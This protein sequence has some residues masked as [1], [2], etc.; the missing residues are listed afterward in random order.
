[1][2]NPTANS[3]MYLKGIGQ[4]RAD[5]LAKEGIWSAWDLLHYFPRAYIDRNALDSIKLLIIKLLA[6]K[7]SFLADPQDVKTKTEYVVTATVTNVEKRTYGKN[8]KYLK[9]GIQDDYDGKA[10]IIFWNFADY[11]EKQYSVGDKIFVCGNPEIDKY[12]RLQFSQ[13]EIHKYDFEEFREYNS[14][15]IPVYKSPDSF[16][17]VGISNSLLRRVIASLIKEHTVRIDETLPDNILHKFGFPGLR[18]AIEELHFPKTSED[19]TLARNRMKFE[20]IFYFELFLALRASGIRNVERGVTISKKSALARKVFENLPFSLT[21]DQIKVVNEIARDMSSGYPM[22]R[23]LQGDVGSGK[24]V[25]AV[26]CMLSAV[27]SGYQAALMVPTEI[28]AE[29]HYHSIQKMLENYPVKVT[30]LLGGQ[31][32]K[33]REQ[34]LSEIRTGEANIIV[35]THSMFEHYV[36][37]N[38]LGLVVIDE[39]HRFGVG[40]RAELISAAR[41][42][43][44]VP[45]MPHILVMSAT[46]IPRTLSMTVYG[47]L[48][49]SI[50]KNMPKNRKPIR[51]KVVFESQLE[52]AY[53]FIREEIQKKHQAYIVFP[54]VEKSEKLELKSAVEHF[55]ILQ[56]EIFPKYKCGL[57]HGQ[58]A[59]N[60]KEEAMTN[61]LN[62]EYD[63]L[64]ATTV[65]EVGIDVAN[66]TVMM[67]NDAH[68]FGLSQLHQLRG[69]VGRGSEQSF[70]I[71][72]TK[73]N[74][75]YELA[76]SGKDIDEQKS[77]I[78]RLKT[79]EKTSDG[80]EI[81]EVDLK[82]RG[83]GDVLGTRQSGLPNFRFL[84]L[85]SD[86]D[87][88]TDAKRYAFEIVERDR[89]LALPENAILRKNFIS[90]YS[91]QGN[92]F[93]IA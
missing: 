49:V 81:A 79:M 88:I 91:R 6:E 26:L 74:Y 33:L 89:R 64:V 45:T 82:L 22:N 21:P 28:L 36:E 18:T 8:R 19:V 13:P 52:T 2:N 66:A 15:L 54:L 78:V 11:Y 83:P 14:N 37:Y 68:R 90:L 63:I 59:W 20:E 17:K 31:R 48:A 56:N 1:M 7:N 84:D 29:Q 50:I 93:D 3:L 75:S 57:L 67:I 71:L 55:E 39:Q 44:E 85:T 46:P 80:F 16:R 10:E 32:K 5:V 65:I 47:D 9:I 38:K 27:D 43:H 24:T 72:A 34:V 53:D 23:L 51:T 12:N 60:E 70:C 58:M 77:N 40:Q 4:A 92:Y 62:K 86:G 30:Q 69:R 35:G 76:R 73:D 42:S 61:F 87:I 25:V 41:K